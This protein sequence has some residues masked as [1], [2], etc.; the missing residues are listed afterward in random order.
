MIES[1]QLTRVRVFAS[2]GH[3][4]MTPLSGARAESHVKLPMLIVVALVS[5]ASAALAQ[6]EGRVS[7]GASVTVNN[8]PDGDVATG[9]GFGP[10][11][12]LNPHKGWG[13]AG[14]FNWFRADLENPGGDGGDFARVRVRPL[15]GGVSYTVGSRS[16]L[17]SFSIVTGPSFNKAQFTG[18]FVPAANESIHA[19]NSWALRPGVGATWTIA[20]RVAIIGFGG[21][22]INRPDVV[23]RNRAG[24]EFRNRWTADSVVLSVGTVYSLF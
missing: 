18:A 6:T 8:T 13:P 9:A 10:L 14:A 3:N 15:M 7:V 20:P 22:L 19:G 5:T 11:V 21:Y 1:R 2:C 16:V 4:A 17:T 24:Q 12:R 23:Y